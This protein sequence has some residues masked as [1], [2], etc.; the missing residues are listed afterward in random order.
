MMLKNF[1]TNAGFTLIELIIVVAIIGILSTVALPSYTEHV[2]DGRRADIQQT[3]IQHVTNLE[4][5]YTRLGGYPDVFAPDNTDYYEFS[6][7]PSAAAAATPTALNDSTT[8]TLTATPI[9]TTSQ[10]ND[11]CG[12]MSIN[13]QGTQ[14]A[15]I[16]GC[17]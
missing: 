5:Q 10:S 13:Q 15:A 14:T 3:M 9:S 6:Y 7:T 11:D 17:W 2:I 12:A 8:Y 1:K 4:R 16:T